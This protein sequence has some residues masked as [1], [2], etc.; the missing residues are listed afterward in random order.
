MTVEDQEFLDALVVKH[1]QNIFEYRH[2]GGGTHVH[3][4]IN[5]FLAGI[6]PKG[7]GG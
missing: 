6:D 7:N 2:L 3:I 5:I 1:G 4:Q